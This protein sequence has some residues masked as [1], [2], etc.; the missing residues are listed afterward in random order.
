MKFI[1][2][3]SLAGGIMG[4]DGCQ[5]DTPGFNLQ[6]QYK[7]ICVRLCQIAIVSDQIVKS[8]S[9]WSMIEAR[10]RATRTWAMVRPC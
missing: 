6:L 1:L 7:I 8:E 2:S 9:P 4:Y 10:V 5:T 3:A